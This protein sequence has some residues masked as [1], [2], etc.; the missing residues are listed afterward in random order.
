M[1]LKTTT[2]ALQLQLSFSTTLLKQLNLVIHVNYTCITSDSALRSHNFFPWINQCYIFPHK[3][4]RSFTLWKKNQRPSCWYLHIFLILPWEASGKPHTC[5]F[6]WALKWR[7]H[8]RTFFSLPTAGL[9]PLDIHLQI[10]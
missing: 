8:V 9:F 6:K 10:K 2:S 5:I 3:I 1:N 7:K 4:L